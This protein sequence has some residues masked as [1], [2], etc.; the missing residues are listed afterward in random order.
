MAEGL[1]RWNTVSFLEVDTCTKKGERIKRKSYSSPKYGETW[2]VSVEVTN[3]ACAS[4]QQPCFHKSST[5]SSQ[6]KSLA[7][8]KEELPRI[9]P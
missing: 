9:L 4:S 8:R 1:E 7:W 5:E 6:L 3:T 2:T